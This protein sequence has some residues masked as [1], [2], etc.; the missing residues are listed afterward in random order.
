MLYLL[1]VN[2][3]DHKPVPIALQQIYGVGPHT[4]ATVC[5]KLGI[6]PR[7]RL[8]DLAEDKVT[9]LSALLNTMTI[10]AEL[11]RETK[12]RVGVMV[13]TGRYRGAR[14][15]AMLP[16]NG[17]RTHTNRRTAKKLNGRWVRDFTSCTSRSPLAQTPVPLPPTRASPLSF[18]KSILRVLPRV[19]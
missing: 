12:A 8:S 5:H 19:L 4:S 1:G 18:A 15:K 2:L 13:Q 9:K 7:C 17:Q 11:K 3:P 10:D 16:V 6:H 14:H